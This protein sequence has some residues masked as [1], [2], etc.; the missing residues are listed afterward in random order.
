MDR[1]ERLEW[2]LK[3]L[4]AD[5]AN[6]LRALKHYHAVFLVLLSTVHKCQQCS[7]RFTGFMQQH[8][9]QDKWLLGGEWGLTK[10]DV[11]LHSNM[12]KTNYLPETDSA[13]SSFASRMTS[14]N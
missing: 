6:A 9:E 4:E 14:S 12:A 5:K 13:R 11:L 8:P 1:V 2:R 3:N 10:L 7:T